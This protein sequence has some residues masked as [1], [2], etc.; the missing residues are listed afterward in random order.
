MSHTDLTQRMA[1]DPVLRLLRLTLPFKWEI[2]LAVLLGAATVGSGVG[3]MATSSYII[4]AAALHPSIAALEV[5][6]VGVR[7]FGVARGVFR[8][9]ERYVSHTV[10]FKLLARLRVWF[11]ERLEPLAPARLMEE[12]SGDLL[13]RIVG[14]VETLQH[15]Y[16][17]VLAPPAVALV[18]TLGMWIFFATYDPRL[19]NTLLVFLFL[20]GVAVPLL[21][22]ALGRTAGR[23]VIAARAALA[24]QVLDGVQGMAEL[25]AFGQAARQQARIAALNRDVVRLQARLARVTALSSAL[26]TMF[27]S[28][29]TLA[30][31]V[32]AIPLVTSGRLPGVLLA[33]LALAAAASFEAVAP[34]PLALQQLASSRAAAERL[35]AIVDAE[36][37]VKEPAHPAEV[38]GPATLDVAD[39]TFRYTPGQPPALDDVSFSLRPGKLVAVVGPSGAGKSTLVNVLLRF[40]DYEDGSVML[41]GHELREYRGEDVREHFA[42]VPQ[43]AHLFNGSIRQNLLLAH[44]SAAQVQLDAAARHAGLAEFIASLPEGYD[45]PIGEQG[46]LLS[47]G[48]RQRLAIAQAILKGRP[49]LL[50]DEPT[51]NLDPATERQ[52]MRD[53]LELAHDRAVLL[54]THR[55]V[56]LEAADEILVLDRGKIVKRG[57]E[58]DL[59]RQGGLYRRLWRLQHNLLGEA[60]VVASMAEK[61]AV[62]VAE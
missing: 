21:A 43:R 31:L 36:P 41:A 15:F 38:I 58:R 57:C 60:P 26:L 10:T 55:L 30:V 45:T 34:L 20:A 11:F 12:R 40:W 56:G 61:P 33:V 27:T 4:S 1:R 42:V 53:L 23:E 3:L 18:T 37:R 16:V 25:V 8:Y 6:I 48:E 32:V 29:A 44:P 28:A 54:I 14:D 50:L 19:A 22:Y 39:L 51:A 47:G 46:L 9:L 17:R 59:L 62:A 49:L 52:V 7:F 35:F 2:V 24:T 5:A 13:A